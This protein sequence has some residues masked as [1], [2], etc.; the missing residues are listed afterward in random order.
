MWLN[1]LF[2]QMFSQWSINTSRLMDLSCFYSRFYVFVKWGYAHFFTVWLYRMALPNLTF[3]FNYIGF[4]LTSF[5]K[6]ISKSIFHQHRGLFGP[7][8]VAHIFI[9]FLLQSYQKV[10]FHFRSN[11]RLHTIY[12]RVLQMK[13][14][15]CRILSLLKEHFKNTFF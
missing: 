12:K 4:I 14:V 2:L 8:N 11:E 7:W 10:S 9:C 3:S 5:N 13:T 15:V 6:V 1:F